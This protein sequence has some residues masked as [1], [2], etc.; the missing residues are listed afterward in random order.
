MRNT[1]GS[2]VL[3]AL[4]ILTL[5]V[6]LLTTALNGAA[7]ATVTNSL[8][9][10][11]V[12]SLQAEGQGERVCQVADGSS[13]APIS[14]ARMS[15]SPDGPA[16]TRFPSGTTVVYVI[17]DYD[18]ESEEIRVKI[19]DDVGAT[20]VD[21]TALYSGRGSESLPAAPAGGFLD[22]PYI[23]NWYRGE[24][25]ALTV[26][27]EVTREAGR[28]TPTATPERPTGTPTS[29]PTHT[30]TSTPTSTPTATPTGTAIATGTPT[31]TATTTT[32]P[33]D[34]RVYLP[35]VLKRR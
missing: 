6:V 34:Y 25:L 29:T 26:F 7:G 30:A 17:F 2:E 18:V 5:A 24:Y 16:I 15:D 9:P 12:R 32:T 13:G 20:I 19:M 22:G 4:V 35:C 28:V 11:L 31:A 27:W 1:P 10:G 3:R 33:H 8:A 21:H 23:T 14:N